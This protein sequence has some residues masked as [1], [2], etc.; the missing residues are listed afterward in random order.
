MESARDLGLAISQLC[1][2]TGISW[3]QLSR[4]S[5]ID[6]RSLNRYLKGEVMP[7]PQ[8]LSRI[9]AV[10]N[11][12]ASI[13]D[14]LAPRCRASR[15]DV[16]E[17]LPLGAGTA[18]SPG[19]KTPEFQGRIGG[20][21][22][23]AMTPFVQQLDRLDRGAIPRAEDRHWAAA[24]WARWEPL[25]DEER[26]QRQEIIVDVLLGDERS[27]GLAELICLAS[28]AA[29]ADRAVEALR[30]AQL[31]VRLAERVPGDDWRLRLLGWVEP[32]LAN[33]QRVGGDLGASAK[34]LA[35]ADDLW[36]RGAAGAPAGLLDEARRL[37]LKA[38]L[39]M[40]FGRF[41]EAHSLLTVA[42]Q[43]TRSQQTRARLLTKQANTLILAGQ[44][45]D[46]IEVLKEAKPLLDAAE[47]PRLLFA[48]DFNKTV[49]LLHLE[50]YGEA[51][52]LLPQVEERA[53]PAN[54]LDGIRLHWLRG[55]TWAGL[56]RRQEARE[57]LA[58]VRGYFHAEAIAYD[59]A[60]ASV[61]LGT[62]LLEEGRAR[63]VR[64]LA[65]EMMWIF[66]SQ[67]IHQEALEALALF[68]HAAKAEQAQ[69]DWARRLVRYLYRAQSNPGMTFER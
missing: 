33:A 62:L 24:L 25:P 48:H 12:P 37:D 55:R 7:S 46:A 19:E 61:E 43:G 69:A 39:L 41:E 17:A 45:E 26:S 44:Y 32:F 59:Y 38:S 3:R 22:V 29:A 49:S 50:R 30:L 68:C 60:V 56:G 58:R 11:V 63:E 6:K 8:T 15:L 35:R 34:T 57:A 14:R 36:D 67:G 31:A 13:F 65:E 42:L 20:A 51:A 10:F 52:E 53:D 4:Q 66:K 2:I 18:L 16:E 28:E 21:A 27:W 9:A 5:G 47:D 23:A 64:E 54:E 1:D 40:Y